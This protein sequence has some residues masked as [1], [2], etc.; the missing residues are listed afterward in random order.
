L[1]SCRI[2]LAQGPRP[3]EVSVRRSA[4]KPRW[5]AAGSDGS[6]NF[7]SGRRH[8]S[9]Q[10]RQESV[11]VLHRL[12]K[13]CL[14][15]ARVG[16]LADLF[17]S[18]CC[19]SPGIESASLR[20]TCS[21]VKDIDLFDVSESFRAIRLG[22]RR[23]ASEPQQQVFWH[24]CRQNFLGFE[25]GARGARLWPAAGGQRR[26]PLDPWPNWTIS[27]GPVAPAAL[28]GRLES[29][30]ELLR[31]RISGRTQGL[32]EKAGSWET[33]AF[34]SATSRHSVPCYLRHRAMGQLGLVLPAR[35]AGR[36]P[37][38]TRFRP[39]L[40][41]CPQALQVAPSTCRA[42]RGLGLDGERA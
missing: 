6:T 3:A 31:G 11:R 23:S 19:A 15:F 26:A 37:G 30:R 42:H 10:F 27:L 4:A 8:G 34:S 12:R 18:E 32:A 36:F 28:G 35:N 25:L 38:S 33:T 17:T 14:E 9:S 16:Q 20:I 22:D 39:S 41:S 1:A 5:A 21:V 29:E 40:R 24:G 13:S 2:I 7:T